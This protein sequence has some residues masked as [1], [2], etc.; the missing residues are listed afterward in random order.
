[1]MDIYLYLLLY[2]FDTSISFSARTLV[3]NIAVR[4]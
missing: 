3:R 2:L 4:S 1:M